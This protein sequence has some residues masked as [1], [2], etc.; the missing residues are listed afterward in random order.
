MDDLRAVPS[1]PVTVAA[2]QAACVPLDIP[3]NVAVAAD[4][5]RRAGAR[6]ADLLVLPEL[7]LTGY[8]LSGIAAAPETYAFDLPD[9]G[10][11]IDP[12]TAAESAT[13]PLDA[14]L[15]PLSVACAETHT[16][17]VVSAPT[18]AGR[19][20]GLRISALVLGRDGQYAARYDKQH[21][22]TVER[23]A[24]FESGVAGCTLDVDGWRLGLGVCRDSSFP[25]HARAAALD[26]C[27]AYLVSAMFGQGHGAHK[28]ATL[29]PA[30]ALDN[31]CYVVVANHNG[32]SG[33]LHGCGHS[34]IWNPDGTLLVDIDMGIDASI[35]DPGL[36]VARLDPQTLARARE[37]DFV[38]LDPSFDAPVRTR[39]TVVLG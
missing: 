18:R 8:E 29:G 25:E 31:A 27:H 7:F 32:P 36:A 17:V 2:G 20:G 21:V 11:T 28:R 15:D 9:A 23:A 24:G 39:T 10:A 34:A 33:P 5:V 6:G 1:V 22:D 35:A 12:D 38:L 13:V 19:S 37:E 16:A 3:A 4:L 14:R 30:R 26:G